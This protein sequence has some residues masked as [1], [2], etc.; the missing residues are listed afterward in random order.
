MFLSLL[1]SNFQECEIYSQYHPEI[2]RSSQSR[3][4]TFKRE[5]IPRRKYYDYWG[6]L[7]MDWISMW[8]EYRGKWGL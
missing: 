6:L 7:W 1:P 8:N 5:R 4:K 2:S 3:S